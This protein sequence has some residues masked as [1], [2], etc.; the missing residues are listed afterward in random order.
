[1]AYKDGRPAPV[2]APKKNRKIT[3]AAGEQAAAE[4]LLSAD[5]RIVER[6]WRCRSGELDI[7]ASKDGVLVIVEVR[8]RSAGALRFGSPAESVNTRK[9]RQVRET[10]AVYLHQTGQTMSPVR[11]DVIAVILDQA[12]RPVS[13]EHLIGVF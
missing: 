11:F 4:L 8:S 3:G 13:T 9:I 5:Y 6:N 7:I 10:A 2:P 1:M 12:G